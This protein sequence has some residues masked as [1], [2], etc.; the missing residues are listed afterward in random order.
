[1]G[2]QVQSTICILK[3]GLKYVSTS[4]HY[5][6]FI[7]GSMEVYEYKFTVQYVY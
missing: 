4:L 5:N 7:K 3:E 1:M 6:M 2:V